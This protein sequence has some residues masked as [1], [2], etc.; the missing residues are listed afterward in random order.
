MECN[1]CKVPAEELTRSRCFQGGREEEKRAGVPVSQELTPFRL[2]DHQS[3]AGMLFL[4]VQN[5][6]SPSLGGCGQEGKGRGILDHRHQE[7]GSW[8]RHPPPIAV[9]SGEPSPSENLASTCPLTVRVPLQTLPGLG[10]KL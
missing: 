1:L 8:D 6:I 7:Q 4:R 2:R 10:T 5:L 3:P 9:P